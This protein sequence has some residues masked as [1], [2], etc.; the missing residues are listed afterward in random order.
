M[1]LEVRSRIEIHLEFDLMS[2]NGGMMAEQDSMTQPKGKSAKGKAVYKRGKS[3]ASSRKAEEPTGGDAT[4][5][6]ENHGSIDAQDPHVVA[7]IQ[8]RAYWLYEAG[9]FE[10]GHDLEHWL[11]A[12][13]Q[14]RGL[15]DQ[16]G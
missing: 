3:D 6:A 5:A 16:N 13:R 11:E 7:R 15:S 10:H 9:G 12:E 1:I 14:V 2:R 8:Q 4:E